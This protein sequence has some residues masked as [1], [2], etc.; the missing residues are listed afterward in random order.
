MILGIEGETWD[1]IDGKK[2]MRQSA[3]DELNASFI[4]YAFKYGV[5]C[6]WV[7]FCDTYY[8]TL[9][10]DDYLGAS[11]QDRATMAKRLTPFVV[12]AW[13]IGFAELSSSWVPGSDIDIKNTKITEAMAVAATKMVVADSESELM[14][15]YDE[16]LVEIDRL[17][18]RDVE[19]A[20]TAE[21]KKQLA[22]LGK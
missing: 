1:Y 14:S 17:G 9:Y 5:L 12:D 2:V 11:P 3:Q 13:D 10:V 22:Q 4:D 21:H 7:P 16:A 20:L 8:W 15:I 18:A 19:A 6:R